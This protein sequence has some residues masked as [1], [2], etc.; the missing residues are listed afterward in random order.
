MHELVCFRQVVNFKRPEV[1]N[2]QRPSVVNFNGFSNKVSG[3]QKLGANSR[4][5][6]KNKP[7]RKKFFSKK[8]LGF[9]PIMSF[10][11]FSRQK[12]I[13]SLISSRESFNLHERNF[14]RT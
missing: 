2:L 5:F 7:M 14:R 3:I 8:F 9:Q 1:V 11:K 13:E 12:S 4:C 6:G 10:E